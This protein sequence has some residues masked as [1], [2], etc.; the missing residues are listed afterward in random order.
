MPALD[1]LRGLGVLGVV[2]FHAEGA[3][4][5]G[6]LGV[7]LFFVLSGYLITSILLAEH[8]AT[9]KIDLYAFWVRRARRLLP[10]LLALMPAIAL[11]GALLAKPEEVRSIRGDAL[12]TL[13]YVANW[14]T[15]FENKSY[16]EIFAA[17]SPLEHTWS[18]AI[19]EQF[20]VLWPLLVGLLLVVLHRT[21]RALL[22]V[23]IALALASALA[24]LLLYDAERTSRVYMGSDTRAAAILVGAALAV[25]LRPGAELGARVVR[26]LDVTGALAFVGLAFAWSRL[27]GQ[28]AL[29]YHGGFWLTELGAL[30][31][32]A[33]AVAG[34]K[35]YVGRALALRPLALVGT[36][37][38]GVYLWHWPV[39]V[40]LSTERVHLG[41]LPLNSL[42]LAVTFAI[43]I[44]SY[45]FLERPI[46]A[47]GIS[48]GRPIVVVPAAFAAC[49][50]L[51]V[52]GTRRQ[53]RPTPVAEVRPPPKRDEAPSEPRRG[54]TLDTVQP[55]E[56]PTAADLPPGT[57]RILVLG[58]SVAIALGRMLR[59]HQDGAQAWVAE[60]GV[61]QCSI[62]EAEVR[63]VGGKRIEEGTSCA[64][65]WVSDVNE[66]HPDMTLLVMGGGFLGP[67]TC[68]PDWRSTYAE[69]LR[70]LLR[71]MGEA[72]GRVVIALVPYPEE[73]WRTSDM[74]QRVDCFNATLEEVAKS[75]GRDALDLK[76][77]VC[78]TTDCIK[79]SNDHA[80][81]PDGLHFGGI[82]SDETSIWTLAELRR[83]ASP[84]VR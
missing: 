67:R 2:F 61:Q 34:P 59:Y 53:P 23:T 75:E 29:L 33:C 47:R 7:D 58:D 74:I 16:W 31:L 37:S 12:A 40:A 30:A 44:V 65:D 35:S 28:S 46:R 4:R 66:L 45:R 71:E 78:P 51:V 5:G 18:L 36:I 38:Y 70:F 11:H 55:N 52:A 81:R 72:A 41:A 42:R 43:A 22:V 82:G 49:V 64:R 8:A 27:D 15:I 68:K 32:I 73:R 63:W 6:Y 25:L 69:R 84:G 20:Y 54:P 48:F 39:D 26:A 76:S 24:M 80:V 77:H 56:L 13:G 3:L 57:L 21:K 50:A 1:G 9:G 19:E 10:A 83:I 14:R 62:R 79:I 60:R 17:P